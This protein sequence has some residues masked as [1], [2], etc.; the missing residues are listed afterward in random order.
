MSQK[1]TI[2]LKEKSLQ[3]DKRI[4]GLDVMRASAILMVLFS[5]LSF[6]IPMNM[7]IIRQLTSLFGFLG[8]EIFFVL[9][10]FLIGKIL[11]EMVVLKEAFLWIDLLRF[12]KRRWLR[13]FPN[14]FLVLFATILI[15]KTLE[16][17]IVESWKYF[18]FIQNLATPMPSFFPES[19]SLSIEEFAYV[20]LPLFLWMGFKATRFKNKSLLFLW[21][22]LGLVFIFIGTKYWYF[23]TTN[24]TTLIQWNVALKA[25]VLYR[26]DSIFIGV[27]FS[28]LYFNCLKFWKQYKLVCLGIGLLLLLLM[29]VGVGFFAIQIETYPFFW[30]VLYLPLT[31][32]AFALFLPFASEW[33]RSSALIKTPITFVSKISYAIY[34]IHY[35]ILFQLMHHFFNPEQ[36][37]NS[38]L[39]GY[40]CCYLTITFLFSWILYR[41]YE[42]PF[43]GLRGQN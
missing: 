25:V 6:I 4:F 8:V 17:P 7:G 26:L 5:H 43:M 37:N 2:R 16:Y 32:L 20:L 29:F 23:L 15:A 24:N 38:Q 39:F 34:L 28:W 42:K 30:N 40:A 12:L 11:Y 19:W 41:F 33:N 13:T 31:S 14:Y 27:L 18:F 9:S 22:V 1:Y 36:Y 21:I 3:E 10:G 35:S